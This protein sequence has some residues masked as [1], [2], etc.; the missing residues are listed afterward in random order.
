MLSY[1]EKVATYWPEFAQNGKEH[2]T[3]AD[4]MRHDSGLA[5]LSEP[6]EFNWAWTEN[7]KQNKI[8]ALIEKEP[9]H[10]LP[11]GIKRV[12]HSVTRDLLTNEI[13]RRVEPQ[14][15]TM[16]EYL[17]QVLIPEHGFGF[18]I[19]MDDETI[20]TKAYDY[21][22]ISGWPVFKNMMKTVD[23]GRYSCVSPV[24]IPGLVGAM[25]KMMAAYKESA[26]TENR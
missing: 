7:I 13:F 19:G 1:D 3:V 20:A 6:I 21:K 4:V 11:H 23:G 9:L 8:G 14:G 15:R 2:L 22:K 12:Y 25:K 26:P 5:G 18:R 17:N 24:Q 16:G 10:Y